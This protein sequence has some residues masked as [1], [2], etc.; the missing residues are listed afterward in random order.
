[1]ILHSLTSMPG[2]SG[3]YRPITLVGSAQYCREVP[4]AR[5]SR[6]ESS[7]NRYNEGSQ[8]DARQPDPGEAENAL[9]FFRASL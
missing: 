7:R 5:R 2:A 9:R 3:T 6:A 8:H 4:A 1:M